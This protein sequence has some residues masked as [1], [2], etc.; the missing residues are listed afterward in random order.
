ME[1]H[2]R[3]PHYEAT[4]LLSAPRLAERLGVGELLIKCEM[5]RLG[6]MSFKILGASWASYRAIVEHLGQAA[7]TVVDR[8]GTGGAPERLRP[9]ALAAATDGNHGMAIAHFARLLGFEARIFVP[10]GTAP[11]RIED[12]SAEGASVTV[13]AGAYDDAVERSAEEAGP[14][15][16]VVS[17]TSWP[18]YE[19]VPRWVIEGY[20]TMFW[21]VDDRLDAAGRPAPDVVVVPVGR[22]RSGR[23]HREP[24]V[25]PMKTAPTIVG[26]EPLDANC[27]MA[28]AA[29]RAAGDRPR[30]PPFDHGRPQ[31]RPA[32]PRGLAAR[33][34]RHQHSRRCR[35]R[36]GH[37]RPS[38]NWPPSASKR[39]RPARPPSPV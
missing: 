14:R 12:I 23:R 30:P 4:R 17:D 34:R 2:R 6:L 24:L 9:F 39:A 29:G 26:V 22:R 36:N 16:L 8:R 35:G 31:L 20:S 7:G 19:R 28:S 10:E 32:I 37:A 33:L 5:A 25:P 21:E 1:L 3:L 13:V 15:C 18:G 27:V 38:G 11:S